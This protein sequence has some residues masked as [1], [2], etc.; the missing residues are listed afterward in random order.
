MPNTP[1]IEIVVNNQVVDISSMDD[2]GLKINYTLEEPENFESKQG[3]DAI[4]L[5]LPATKNNDKIFNTYHNPNVEDLGPVGESLSTTLIAGGLGYLVG[6]I[7]SILGGTTFATLR[8]DTIGGAGE[9]LTYTILTT[10]AGYPVGLVQP[11]S[12][13]TGTGATMRVD[14]LVMV[15]GFRSLMTASINVNGT[16]PILKGVAQMTSASRS[17]KPEAYIL[18]VQGGNG[19]WI[20]NMQNLT[21]WDCLSTT[22]HTFDVATVEASW[23]PSSSGGYD[24]DED[25]DY[26]YAPVRYR[27]PFG[28]N[29]DTV[30]IYALRPSISIYWMII[31]AFR[32]FGFTVNSNFLNSQYFRRMVLPWTWGSFYDINN[33]ITDGMKFK[34]YGTAIDATTLPS[35]PTA[36]F[37]F[38]GSTPGTAPWTMFDATLGSGSTYIKTTLGLSDQYFQMP[39]VNP[40]N[41]YDNFNLYSFDESTGTMQYDFNPPAELAPFIGNNVSINF[42]LS[43]YVGI[44]D[45]TGGTTDLQ[46]E[47]NKNGS[48]VSSNSILPGGAPIGPFAS[49]P[50]SSVTLPD[51]KIS[52]TPTVYNFTVPNIDAGDTITFNLKAVTTAIGSSIQIMQAGWLDTSPSNTA[53]SDWQYNPTTQQWANIANNTPSPR[54]QAMYSTFEMTGLQIQLGNQV[55]FQWYD[56]FRNYNFLGMLGGLVESFDWEIQTDNINKVVTIEPFSDT[57]LPDYDTNGDYLGDI[58]LTGYFDATRILD[59]TNKRDVSNAEYMELFRNYEQQLDFSFKQDGSDGG[60]N[61]FA[62]RYKGL[63]VSKVVKGR[64]NNAGRIDNGLVAAIP[65]A[66]RY[67]LPNRFIQGNR[68]KN[69]R[70]F[71]ATMHYRHSIWKA[72]DGATWPAPQLIAIIP[73]NINDSS[74]SAVTQVFEPKIVFWAGLKDPAAFGGWRWVGDPASPY[75]DGGVP[76]A[77]DFPLPF[78]FAVNYNDTPVIAGGGNKDPILSFS[79]QLVSDNTGAPVVADGLMKKYFLRRLAIMRNG[80]LYNPNMRLNLNDVCNFTHQ[81]CI[82]VDNAIYALIG[83]EGYEPINDSSCKCTMWKVVRPQA[84]DLANCY[85]SETSI[86]T[87]PTI[88]SN[89]YDLKYNQLLL[90]ITDIPQ[91]T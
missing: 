85:P 11:L 26:V 74:A 29:D 43:L 61:I 22:P 34:A 56:A 7:C 13:G 27:Q 62:A 50:I 24:S 23:N 36:G 86:T 15:D 39:N 51:M 25:H 20:T 5:T 44:L 8:V 6:D 41:G 54:W 33:Q 1:F 69:N 79:D 88:L 68:Q 87:N 76:S 35:S 57:T 82:K 32:Q 70:F 81:E 67:M 38:T 77:I 14:G 9:I 73:E 53:A 12:G 17:D 60:Q 19:E 2:L 40:P 84:I 42:A 63:N 48:L 52:I 64:I 78:M 65:A 83:I 3:S 4:D 21:L 28:V 66:A 30:N 47:I 31:R 49:Y 58:N 55:H 80:Q 10:G 46:L 45:S 75:T 59:W 37:F 91:V 18:D 89:P 90:F 71:S 16:V 72:L